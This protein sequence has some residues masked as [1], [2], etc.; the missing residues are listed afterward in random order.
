[1]EPVGLSAGIKILNHIIDDLYDFVKDEVG[2]KIKKSIIIAKLPSLLHKIDS[3]RKVKTLWQLDQAVDIES[4]YCDS[5]LIFRKKDQKK[6]IRKRI[7]G[8]SD[9]GTKRNVVIRGIA[10]QG[11]SI[12][13][14]HLCAREF[15]D[16]KRIPVFIEL[17]RIQNSE[18]LLEHI[19]RFFVMH[20]LK[21]SSN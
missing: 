17:R 15:E 8:V 3:V 2:K 13:L 19:N 5:H 18:T 9:I 7:G 21:S 11:K 14:R 6:E 1:M 10:G 20:P 16:G 12:L 4:F